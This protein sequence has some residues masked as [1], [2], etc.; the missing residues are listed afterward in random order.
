M[1]FAFTPNS[2]DVAADVDGL[3]N[4]VKLVRWRYYA[5]QDGVQESL[6][7]LTFLGDPDPANFIELRDVTDSWLEEKVLQKIDVEKIKSL[8]TDQVIRR[9]GKNFALRPQPLPE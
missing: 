5:E 9:S 6:S 2:I 1:K 7:G 8:L 4:V 3:P